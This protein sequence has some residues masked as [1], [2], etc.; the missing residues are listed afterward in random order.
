MEHIT[1][2]M[3]MIGAAHTEIQQMTV[4]ATRDNVMHMAKALQSIEA[5]HAA[6]G[7]IAA[8]SAAAPAAEQEAEEE[9]V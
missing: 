6:L 8:G 4:Q 1:D 3:E 5:A 2:V 9:D 7:S